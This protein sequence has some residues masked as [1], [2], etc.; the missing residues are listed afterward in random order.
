MVGNGTASTASLTP[1]L[2]MHVR[3]GS[4]GKEELTSRFMGNNS[5]EPGSG[6]PGDSFL[7][8]TVHSSLSRAAANGFHEGNAPMRPRSLGSLAH[9]EDG[10]G[11]QRHPHPVTDD[12]D[13]EDS[14][15]TPGSRRRGG[16]RA[17]PRDM[18]R[19]QQKLNLQRAS[20][21]LETAHNPHHPELG[22]PGLAGPILVGAGGGGYDAPR[23][24]RINKT[25]ERTGMEYLVVRRHQN[26]VARSLARLA[27]LPGIELGSS[28]RKPIPSAPAT[29]P[30]TAHSKRGS[31]SMIA[32]GISNPGGS[33][34][35]QSLR[36]REPRDPSVAALL[37]AQAAVAP[38]SSSSSTKRP[39]TPRRAYSCGLTAGAGANGNGYD[40]QYGGGGG[41]AES[42]RGLSGSSLVDRSVE[43]ETM[44][45]LRNLWD[46]NLDLSASQE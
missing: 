34:R 32:F 35:P 10:P 4:S 2:A 16:G 13:A 36:E 24:P 37:N 26:P 28:Q 45:L 43:A 8:S 14:G 29:R 20:S 44:V 5:Q 21:T 31:E 25:L 39:G 22:I 18:N 19:T 17:T 15:F 1:D 30:G 6:I 27:N 23:D 11:H 41:G 38:S 33:G 46:K 9:E 12:E 3:T 40:H 42:T 7:I